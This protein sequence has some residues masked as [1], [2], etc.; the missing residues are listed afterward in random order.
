MES[1]EFELV[2]RAQQ[3]DNDAMGALLLHFE[4]RMRSLI[5]RLLGREFAEVLS[6]DDVL[7]HAYTEIILNLPRFQPRT[8]ESLGV[9][10][11]KL[12]E[13]TARDALRALRAEKRGGKARRMLPNPE[14]ALTA[15]FDELTGMQTQLTPSSVFAR[16]EILQ[17]LRRALGEL[18][19][20]YQVVIRIYDL[21]RRGIEAAA[22]AIGRSSGA[23]H[24][25][26]FRALESLRQ[27]MQPWAG[28][29]VSGA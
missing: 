12:A 17:R 29:F 1:P 21:E 7:Q 16:G 5:R 18:P 6:V 19:E 11:S 23:T 20:H 10:V 2:R 14:Q 8:D 22:A 13:S 26:R 25:L 15:L 27:S 4:P 28:N 24:L 9:W 3:G